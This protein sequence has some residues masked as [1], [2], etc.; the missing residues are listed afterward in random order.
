V[1]WECVHSSSDQEI[2][3]Q[4]VNSNITIISLAWVFYNNLTST[5]FPLE[6]ASQPN[7][8]FT[9]YTNL[10]T[11]TISEWYRTDSICPLVDYFCICHIRWLSFLWLFIFCLHD[12]TNWLSWI[13]FINSSV[14]FSQCIPVP[15]TTSNFILPVHISNVTGLLQSLLIFTSFP[16]FSNI[17]PRSLP[18]RLLLNF[19]G[20]FTFSTFHYNFFGFTSVQNSF[21]TF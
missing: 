20:C 15:S 3:L 5:P 9:N 4:S 1:C 21:S 13:V 19:F 11:D 14:K 2:S 16:V 10:S 12:T 6:L 7:H 8:Q 18:N 17:R